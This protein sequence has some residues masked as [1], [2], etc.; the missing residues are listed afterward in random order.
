[1]PT[2]KF[3]GLACIAAESTRKQWLEL[4]LAAKVKFAGF[5][6]KEHLWDNLSRTR[7][8][9]AASAACPGSRDACH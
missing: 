5:T 4:K 1:M 7:D 3:A 6:R 8:F 2:A 9:V